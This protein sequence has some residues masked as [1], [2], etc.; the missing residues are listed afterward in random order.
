M[1]VFGLF[2]RRFR[3]HGRPSVWSVLC[4]RV[5]RFHLP[6]SLGSTGVTRFL[7][8]MDALTPLGR[9][10]GPPG[11]CTPSVPNGAPCLVHSRCLP[12]CLP[13][14]TDG[15][16]AFLS[17]HLF[18]QPTFAVPLA[19]LVP[20]RILFREAWAASRISRRPNGLIPSACRIEFTWPL[21]G[22]GSVTDWQFTSGS[23][24]PGVA[25]TQ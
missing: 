11:P 7:A 5:L 16:V 8:T 6:A 20:A 3:R 25:T 10:L 9:L 2:R 22:L 4:H 1:D 17:V 18:L 13:S 14:P 15:A 12:F 23:S 19:F 24:P 21:L